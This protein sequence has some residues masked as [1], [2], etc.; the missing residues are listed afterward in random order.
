MVHAAIRPRRNTTAAVGC[1]AAHGA[2]RR[3]GAAIGQ[4]DGHPPEAALLTGAHSRVEADRIDFQAAIHQ[5]RQQGQ[6]TVPLTALL[7]C[8]HCR[9]V[10]DHV[11]LPLLAQKP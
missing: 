7:A 3:V 9:A 11:H 6:G 2:D 1:Q 5:L 10:T 8:T 4:V